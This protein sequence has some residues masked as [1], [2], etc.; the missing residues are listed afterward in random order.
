[1]LLPTA[2]S[3]QTGARAAA[4]LLQDDP[5]PGPTP[6][7]GALR[8]GRALTLDVA[9]A[10][11]VLAAAPPE[12]SGAALT[13]ALPLPDGQMGRFAVTTTTVMAPAL[14]A[15]YPAIGTYAGI[16]LDDRTATVR[17]DVTP[18]GFHAQILS[19]TTGTIYIDP[20]RRGD[21]QHYLSFFKRDM[22]R[23][24]ATRQACG[25]APPPADLAA[26]AQRRAA[27]TPP[28]APAEIVSGGALRT[29]RLAVAANGEYTQFFGGTVAAAQA[30]IVTTVNRVVGVFEKE[31][32]VRMVLVPNNDALIYTN[33]ATDPYTNS[34]GG[35]MVDENQPVV[36]SIIGDNNYD[37]GHV[38]STGGGGMAFYACVCKDDLKARGVTGS[39]SPVGDSFDIDY[40]AHEMGHQFS[41]SHPF[42]SES[43]ACNGNRSENAAWEPGSGSSIMAYA[44]ICD[45]DDLQPHS[46]PQFHAGSFEE[47]RAFIVQTPCPV[48]TLTGN[49]P[50]VVNGLPSGKTLPISTPFKLTANGHDPNGDPLTFSWEELDLGPGGSPNAPQVPDET[51]PIFRSFPPVTSPKRYFPRLVDL[52]TNTTDIGE[53]LPEV[54]RTL[55]FKCTARD[56]HNGSAGIVGGVTSS[57]DVDLIV[58]SAAGPFVV[59]APNTGLTWAGGSTESITWNVA[60][61]TANGV[62]CALVNLRLSTDGGFTYP[63]ILGAAV[64]NNGTAT[65][66]VPNVITATARVMVE[67]A[68]NYFFDISDANFSISSASVCAAP[69]ALVV[70]SVTQTTA[71]LRFTAAPG[72]VSY[73]VSTFPAT[74]VQTVSASPVRLTGLLPGVI[75]TVSV[76][77]QCGPNSTSV[78]VSSANFTTEAIPQCGVPSEFAAVAIRSTSATITFVGSP[79]AVSYT[80]TTV[81]ATTPQTVTASPVVLT[82]LLPSTTYR[83][84]ILS[85]C[86]PPTGTSTDTLTF[87]T[88]TPP[89]VNDA[90]SAALPLACGAMVTGTTIGATPDGDPTQVCGNIG[91]D[92]GGVFYTLTGN[93]G[94]VTVTTCNPATTFDTKL[95]VFRGTCGN[96]TCVTGN[97][98][99][100]TP[101]CQT[102]STVTFPSVLNATY[103]VFVTG[104]DQQE[105]PFGLTATC[106]APIGL[107]D[108]ANPNAFQVWPNPVGTASALHLTLPTATATATATLQNVL[109]Q[110]VARHAFRGA[111]TEISTTGLA[112]GTYWLTVQAENLAP[113]V[114][115][116]VVE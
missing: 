89:P 22:L 54:D 39:G 45:T 90:C 41:G 15:R 1:M 91:I 43:G 108:A 95:F 98:D 21:T 79:A 33:G 66:T 85:S 18:A 70:D 50:P 69:T 5:A 30:A 48:L 80:I 55:K 94:V 11:R 56:A 60:G 72:A 35:L 64:P 2:V 46:D 74:S 112:R 38:V 76:V 93:G 81:P 24:G 87:T 83:V 32:A 52:V 3:A 17:L 7:S 62:N 47:M 31:L 78:A 116:V 115:R 58:T 110:Q 67:A 57:A 42:N 49:A 104:Y 106:A 14:A 97:D 59:T 44:G 61:T 65:V 9:A 92:R 71:R 109:G 113:V 114:R 107:A 25:F 111:S 40:V 102:P 63:T 12:A 96:Y 10:R 29:Y 37:I 23:S 86:F 26:S 51:P 20:A 28:G 68:D 8:H 84:T 77:S 75:Y 34:D 53:H 4:E 13:V 6:L 88:L 27:M 36:D 73:T 101:S 105:G 19:A 99:T 82:G 16:G 100:D 103:Y